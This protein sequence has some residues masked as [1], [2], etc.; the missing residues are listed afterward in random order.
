[1]KQMIKVKVSAKKAELETVKTD[2]LIVGVFE[3]QKTNKL[4]KQLD[5]K[6]NGAIKKIINLGDFTGKL[7][8]KAVIYTDRKIASERIMLVGLGEKKNATLDILRKVC[9]FAAKE[10][11]NM[12]VQS[13]AVAVHPDMDGKIGK[14]KC[15]KA[16]AEAIHFGAYRY[17]EFVSGE[18]NGRSKSLTASIIDSDAA[19]V[20]KLSA[21]AKTGDVVGRWQ[22]YARSIANKPANVMYPA[23]VASEARK[24]V[25]QIKGL[26]YTVF[27][28][29]QLKQ[30]KM[31]G[32]LAVGQ[33]SEHRPAMIILK[34][35]PPAAANQ[36]PTALVGKAITFDSGGISLKPAA[37]MG[38]MKMD[39]SGGAAVLGAMAAIAQLGLNVKV[40]GIICAA[41]NAPS[42]KSY[43]PGDII[44]TYSK[45]TVEVQNT[46]AEGRLVL[47][48]G[49]HY[50]KE[51]GAETIVD[52][53]TLTGACMVALGVHKAGVLGNDEK[54]ISKLKLASEQAGEPIWHLPS[55]EEYAEE[56]KSKIAD[57]KNIGSRWGG[58]CT[59]AAFIGQFAEG[60]KWAHLDIAPMMEAGGV[61]KK[62][63]A[64][65]S[66][67][68][69]V[70]LL[71][72]FLELKS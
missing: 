40:Y 62:I 54:L 61:Y 10:A 68:F 15:G 31:G 5:R 16:I 47:S 20:R 67:G 58:A 66:L 65:G 26:S 4:C 17:D 1:M 21:G 50:A 38:E 57:L 39:K 69:G 13:I 23:Q 63:A 32:I 59:A 41:E 36:K 22:N 11:V 3:G 2:M 48:D 9:C 19:A 35:S 29:N 28:E 12:K 30:K 34:Y 53:A 33:G 52:L 25:R 49:I 51:L 8:S 44:T 42:G 70:R 72:E 64:A 7:F 56:I 55:G 45:K 14:D 43:R 37:G 71:T 60:A 6:L 46:D 27:D 18:E 24:I